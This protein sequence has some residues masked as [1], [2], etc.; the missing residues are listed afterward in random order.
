MRH[1]LFLAVKEALNNIVKHS[2]ATE[3]WLEARWASPYLEIIIRD[4]G[5]GLPAA[6]G[7]PAPDAD[8]LLNMRQRLL[9]NGGDMTIG[10]APGG[11]ML[12]RMVVPVS[13]KHIISN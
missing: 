5:R 8:G 4:N 1:N 11:G 7:H 3:V 2:G 12:V 9:A 6:N 10:T 13:Q